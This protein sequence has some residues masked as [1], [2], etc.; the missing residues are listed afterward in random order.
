MERP[1]IVGMSMD[2]L[3]HKRACASLLG[4]AH[5]LR[6]LF[7]R[8]RFLSRGREGDLGLGGAFLVAGV[9]GTPDEADIVGLMHTD[10]SR[11]RGHRRRTGAMM[12]AARKDQMIS[13]EST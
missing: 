4:A 9:S 6:P 7:I 1:D 3:L 11:R 10:A 2:R 12:S 5:A 8:L 13:S